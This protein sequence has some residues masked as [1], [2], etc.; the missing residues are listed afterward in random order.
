VSARYRKDEQALVQVTR[1]R[2]PFTQERT[3][4]SHY[5]INSAALLFVPYE[6]LQAEDYGACRKLL[7][8]VVT[9]EGAKR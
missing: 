8:Q 6:D 7:S 4:N 3:E 9:I 2:A 1:R 5:V